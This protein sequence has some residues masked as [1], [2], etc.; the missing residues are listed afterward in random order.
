MGQMKE[1]R[2]NRSVIQINAGR[3]EYEVGFQRNHCMDFF[4][5]TFDYC[6]FSGVWNTGHLPFEAAAPVT[7]FYCPR[8]VTLC[9][10][11]HRPSVVVC[12]SP[13]ATLHHKVSQWI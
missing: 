12:F 8:S 13:A 2:V 1:E 3:E 9:E 10:R 7:C 5:R 4:Y 6:G 11:Y